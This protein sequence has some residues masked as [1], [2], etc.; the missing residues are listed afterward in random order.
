MCKMGL[1]DPLGYLKHKLWPKALDEGY[2]FASDL[3]SI[4]GLHIKLW[5]YKVMRVPI[6]GISGLPLGVVRQNDIWVLAPWPGIEYIIKGKVVA[7]PKF[8]L[9]WSCE[10]MS[11][12]GLFMHQ[13]CSNY[14]LLNLLFG[15]YRSVWIIELLVI[16]PSPIPK[17]QHT[18]LP[19]KCCKPRSAP[20]LLLFSLFSPLDS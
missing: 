14:A 20:Q 1:H 7:S 18:L 6:L 8:G 19:P 17:L 5:P 12:R 16:L 11:A 10:S 9:W 3:T 15:L 4:G 2:N 13:K